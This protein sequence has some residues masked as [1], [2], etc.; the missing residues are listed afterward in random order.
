MEC[1]RN[2][3]VIYCLQDAQHANFKQLP[4]VHLIS[5]HKYPQFHQ[6]NLDQAY[7]FL[8]EAPKVVKQIAPMTWQYLPGPQDGTVFL[9]WIGGRMANSFATDGYVWADQEQRYTQDFGGYV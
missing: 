2:S 4:H 6:L 9:T 1:L 7:Q 8:F 5:S 3:Y